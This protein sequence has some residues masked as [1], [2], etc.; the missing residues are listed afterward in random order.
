LK[1]AD[2]GQAW[3]AGRRLT[4]EEAVDEALAI[5]EEAMTEVSDCP[6]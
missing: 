5:A 1:A 6:P 4:F 2:F 3:S